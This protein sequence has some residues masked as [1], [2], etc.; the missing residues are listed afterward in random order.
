MTKKKNGHVF[1]V[2]KLQGILRSRGWLYCSVRELLLRIKFNPIEANF[3]VSQ[4]RAPTVIVT[5]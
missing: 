1:T 2:V 3:T 5:H 4:S